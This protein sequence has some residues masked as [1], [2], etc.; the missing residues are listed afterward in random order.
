M[1]KNKNKNCYPRHNKNK[2]KQW[3][4]TK[5]LKKYD[6]LLK[7]PARDLPA[8]FF[9]ELVTG[10]EPATCALWVRRSTDW[11]TPATFNC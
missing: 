3:E 11:A 10:L 1:S 4:I 7:N 6:L 9:L 8:G 5:K 2:A